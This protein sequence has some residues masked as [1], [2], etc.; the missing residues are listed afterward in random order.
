MDKTIWTLTLDG[1]MGTSLKSDSGRDLVKELAI[2]SIDLH[3]D[4]MSLGELRITTECYKRTVLSVE[5]DETPHVHMI[6][7]KT[8]AFARVTRIEFED[9]VSWTPEDGTSEP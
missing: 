5:T 1:Q 4:A 7:P 9:G 6:H 2:T 3:K 8:R